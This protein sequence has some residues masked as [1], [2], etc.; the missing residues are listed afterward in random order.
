[1]DYDTT[2]RYSHNAPLGFPHYY[3]TER[4]MPLAISHVSRTD[5]RNC[6]VGGPAGGSRGRGN[7]GR[8]DGA[9]ETGQSRRRIAVAV[10]YAITLLP[11]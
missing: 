11:L 1:M 10:S 9:M 8:E 3:F 7:L 4:N 5:P 6:P 2:R